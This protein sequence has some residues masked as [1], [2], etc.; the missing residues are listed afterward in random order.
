MTGRSPWR[1]TPGLWLVL[2]LAAVLPIA[3]FIARVVIFIR[4]RDLIVMI[5]ILMGIILLDGLVTTWTC[6]RP[7]KAA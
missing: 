2:K 7:S 3:F 5:G 6:A 1:L 4:A